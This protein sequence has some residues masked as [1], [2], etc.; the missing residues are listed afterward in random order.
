MKMPTPMPKKPRRKKP[1]PGV[2]P[3]FPDK[4]RGIIPKDTGKPAKIVRAPMPKKPRRKKP[5]PFPKKPTPFPG[6]PADMKPD[7][8][9]PVGR[10]VL[11][12]MPGKPKKPGRPK[13]P[14]PAPMPKKPGKPGK[15]VPM[16]MPGGGR[17]VP[18]K[19]K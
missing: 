18:F 3:Y 1:T 10:P 15:R 4:S 2:S 5:A 12:P 6:S 14:V 11:A 8:G 17:R 9:R 19:G 13:R 7:T 16:P